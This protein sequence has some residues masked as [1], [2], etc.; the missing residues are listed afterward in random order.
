MMSD[1]VKFTPDEKIMVTVAL[2]VLNGGA[3]LENAVRSI[4]YQSWPNWEL[5]LLDDGSTDGAINRLT[6]LSDPRIVFI[7]DGQ[8]LGLAYRLNQAVAMAKGKYFARMDHDDLCHP[9]RF[10]RQIAFLEAHP[11]VELL[12]TQCLTMDEQE[13]LIGMLP[14]AINHADICRRPWQGFYMAHPSWMGKTEW[15]RRNAYQDPAPYC[16]EDQ[17]LLLR[18][19]YS[20][21]YH[22]I[23][24]YLLAYRVR[25]HTPWKKQLGTRVAFG[26]MKIRHFLARGK[27]VSAVLSGL[28]EL[29]RVGYDG[30]KEFLHRMSLPVKIGR[31]SILTPEQRQEWEALIMATKASPERT[32]SIKVINGKF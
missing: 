4:L 3:V 25:T 28:I 11:E 20:S 5:L 8:N 29:A 13:R 9:E 19:H 16:C 24:E 23:P 7:R 1:A 32:N 26:K 30:W 18:A 10:V 6:F 27:L 31:R 14:S 21:C 17:E 15:F 12:A 22:T 2:P